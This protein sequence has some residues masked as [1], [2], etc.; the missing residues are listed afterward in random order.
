M[1]LSQTL[2]SYIIYFDMFREKHVPIIRSFLLYT[3]VIFHSCNAC[4]FSL[5]I[6]KN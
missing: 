2:T 3:Y 4:H 1:Q 5:F 6:L